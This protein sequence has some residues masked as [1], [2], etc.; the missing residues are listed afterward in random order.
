MHGCSATQTQPSFRGYQCR[1]LSSA[2]CESQLLRDRSAPE[3]ALSEALRAR[4]WGNI[5]S[6][7]GRVSLHTNVAATQSRFQDA[8]HVS[9]T[10]AVQ[11]VAPGRLLWCCYMCSDDIKLIFRVF[12]CCAFALLTRT[13]TNMFWLVWP[14]AAGKPLHSCASKLVLHLRQQAPGLSSSLARLTKQLLSQDLT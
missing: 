2:A 12:L 5:K 8:S 7:A 6:V 1:Y 9:S 4:S 10:Q 11:G 3:K 14:Q 13:H